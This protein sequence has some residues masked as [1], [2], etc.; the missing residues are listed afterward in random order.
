MT[1]QT[2]KELAAVLEGRAVPNM[3][4]SRSWGVVV[5]RPDGA[6]TVIEDHAGWVYRNRNAF[7]SYQ[8]NG[9]QDLVVEAR[10]WGE[11]DGGEEWA[12]GLS[13]VLGSEEYWHSG[14]GIWLV[15]YKRPDG[16]FAVIGSESGGVYASREE[17][18][19]DE[20]GEKAENH[21]FV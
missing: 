17:F 5:D 13:V 20:Y 16:R 8:Q 4:S 21:A 9:D 19:A 6:L 1:G 14:G 11:W 2:A 7:D 15:F 10:E 18:D 3:P 12:Q